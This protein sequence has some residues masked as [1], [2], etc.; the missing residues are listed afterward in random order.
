MNLK[1]NLKIKIMS[2]LEEKLLSSSFDSNFSKLSKGN[3][4]K[5]IG[6]GSCGRTGSS[7]KCDSIAVCNCPPPPDGPK[8]PKPKSYSEVE[9]NIEP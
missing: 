6:G 7:S 1:F 8:I 5:V 3:M 4:A 2:S 9:M